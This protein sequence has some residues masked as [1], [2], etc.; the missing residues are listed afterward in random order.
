MSEKFK[1][2]LREWRPYLIILLFVL[3][4]RVFFLISAYIPSG[5]M[6]NTILT[7]TRA[8]GLKCSYW[9]SEPAR[10][11]VVIFD[12]PDDPSV[13]YVKRIIGLPGE[14]V[15]I[16]DGSVYIDGVLLQEDY[17]KEE[18]YG[19]FGPYTVPPGHYFMLGDNRN[20][21]G[22]SRFWQQPFVEKSA[23]LGRV[24]LSYWPRIAWID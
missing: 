20:H 17:L 24:Y 6:E 22:D 7:G 14:T 15:M 4:F 2:G 16:I 21:S 5:S 12:Y 23:I 13:L 11:D 19:S 18:P 1:A 8:F 9:F 10:G 3:M